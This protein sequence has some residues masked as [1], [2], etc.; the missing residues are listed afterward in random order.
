MP[1]GPTVTGLSKNQ[2]RALP[3]ASLY[4]CQGRCTHEARQDIRTFMVSVTAVNPRKEPSDT[5]N[6]S[7]IWMSLVSMY[8]PQQT[9]STTGKGRRHSC[10]QT[11]ATPADLLLS[12]CTNNH[13]PPQQM[14]PQRI[15]H[16]NCSHVVVSR[17]K[18]CTVFLQSRMREALK[19]FQT[20]ITSH[21]PNKIQ[22]HKPN[23]IFLRK[24]SCMII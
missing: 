8:V 24:K 14:N 11:Q 3:P 13:V 7:R 10:W 15:P 9:G 1:S 6:A 22:G 19:P 20:I 2:D 12:P 23:S 16:L 18:S 21:D 5:G 17:H 4:S